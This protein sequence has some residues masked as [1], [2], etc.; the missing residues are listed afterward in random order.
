MNTIIK[1]NAI[2]GNINIPENTEPIPEKIIP[3][4]R[5]AKWSAPESIEFGKFNFKSDVWSF[6]KDVNSFFT[7]TFL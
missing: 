7:H 6:G 1:I 4:Q 3:E 2:L 5:P